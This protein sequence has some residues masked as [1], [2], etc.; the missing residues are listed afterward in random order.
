MLVL[1]PKTKPNR[2]CW[3]SGQRNFSSVQKTGKDWAFFVLQ[4]RKTN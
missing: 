2:S 1:I 4:K 3:T